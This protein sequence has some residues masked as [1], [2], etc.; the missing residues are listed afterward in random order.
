MPFLIGT[1]LNRLRDIRPP[2][3]VQT[4]YTHA[5][6]HTDTHTPKV[7]LYSAPCNVGIGQTIEIRETGT[8]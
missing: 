7:I 4:A 1:E 2:K 3:P 5:E 8:D 6:I